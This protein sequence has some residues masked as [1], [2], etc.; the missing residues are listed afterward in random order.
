M[1]EERLNAWS[2]AAGCLFAVVAGW[3][4]L[5]KCDGC[6]WAY[7]LG[8]VVF[9]IG[10]LM[11]YLAS[12][13]Y[14]LATPGTIKN[15]LRIFDH[16]SIYVLIAASYTPVWLSI[17]GGVAGWVGFGVMWAVAI[18]GMGYKLLAIGK[19]PRLSLIIYLAMGWSVVFVARPVWEATPVAGLWW[20]LV[21]GVAYSGGAWFYANGD[22][23]KYFHVIWHLFVLLGTVAHFMF[24]WET[25]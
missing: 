24:L 3:L 16:V 6:D 17:L 22:K 7:K 14:H 15:Q 9:A 12:T 1:K 23:Y 8:V 10:A 4:L 18:G 21:E 25:L 5:A 13:L 2:H 20:L 19:F 11:Q